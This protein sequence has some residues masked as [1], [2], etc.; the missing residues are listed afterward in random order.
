MNHNEAVEKLKTLTVTHG[1]PKTDM[2]LF[3]VSC[4][5]CGKSDRI[6]R[7]EPPDQLQED[8]GPEDMA[9][10]RRIWKTLA[11]SDQT[12]AV[13]KFCQNPLELHEGEARAEALFRG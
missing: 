5:Y 10:H 11:P 7:L 13:C 12:L 4:P 8:I 9:M 3:G 1:L 6:R 2:S